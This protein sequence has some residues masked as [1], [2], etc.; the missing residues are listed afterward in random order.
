VLNANPK[1]LKMEVRKAQTSDI[2]KLIELNLEVHAIHLQERPKLFKKL[3]AEDIRSSLSH[4]LTQESAEIFVCL[5]E[6]QIV[7][8]VL[9]RIVTPPESPVQKVR[10]LL[11]VDQIDVKEGYRR[12]GVGKLLLEAAKEYAVEKGLDRIILDVWNFN[13]EA[14]SFFHSQGF[15]TWIERM[16]IYLE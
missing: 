15:S 4:V 16:G 13:S 1:E 3:S 5:N 8:Y 9:L 6:G 14:I 12:Q 10:T 2:E 7:G 11:Y